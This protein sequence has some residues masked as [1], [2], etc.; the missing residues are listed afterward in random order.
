MCHIVADEVQVVVLAVIAC[1]DSKTQMPLLVQL[2]T[3]VVA[4]LAKMKIQLVGYSM[5]E[6]VV[7]SKVM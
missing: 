1:P 5:I 4:A 2:D 7:G 6:E 3:V